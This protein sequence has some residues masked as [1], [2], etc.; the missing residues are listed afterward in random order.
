M[1]YGNILWTIQSLPMLH[2]FI[3]KVPDIQVIWVLKKNKGFLKTCIIDSY[4]KIKLIILIISNINHAVLHVSW[5]DC[6]GFALT[7]W[8]LI[9]SCLILGEV[10]LRLVDY[11]KFQGWVVKDEATSRLTHRSSLRLWSNKSDRAW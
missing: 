4:C 5:H 6:C 9:L 2:S 10:W 7:R 11:S 8:S 1:V 3:C